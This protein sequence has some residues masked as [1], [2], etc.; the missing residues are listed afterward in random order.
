MNV[1]VSLVR[2]YLATNGFFSEAEFPVIALGS[3]DSV[4]SVTDLDILAV[5]FPG[6]YRYLM[7]D[8]QGKAS[9]RRQR[10]RNID[11]RLSLSDSDIE[12]VIGEVKE[13][14][15]ELNRGATN[16][17]V[18]RTALA[19]IGAF[20]EAEMS[21][22]IDDLLRKGEST[23]APGSRV[24][25]FAFGSSIP[26]PPPAR[27]TVITHG[28]IVKHLLSF[29]EMHDDITRAMQFGD[30]ISSTLMLLLKSGV[31]ISVPDRL[32]EKSDRSA[33]N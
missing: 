2:M 24:R 33:Q 8:G 23:A 29:H 21:R 10:F 13:G 4:R 15:A 31:R 17:D 1:A 6:A 9:G 7:P 30:D 19:R 18:L 25:V 27:C 12:F 22:I 11:S 16:P 28:E 5:R 3:D 14:R 32:M 20:S 26:D